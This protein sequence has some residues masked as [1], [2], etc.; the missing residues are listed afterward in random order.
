MTSCPVTPL[1]SITATCLP[2][3]GSM[4]PR[5]CSPLLA[6]SRSP[7]AAS[8][9]R[10]LCAPPATAATATTTRTAP[11]FPILSPRRSSRPLHCP[12]SIPFRALP[13]HE[14]GELGFDV[15]EDEGDR[16]QVEDG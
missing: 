7:P 14:L 8:A 2:A 4:M 1:S 3:T 13:E 6:T 5:V 11:L 9:A 16:G 12:A 15:P 10:V